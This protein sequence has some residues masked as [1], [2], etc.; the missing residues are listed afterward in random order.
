MKL[1]ELLTEDL[2]KSVQAAIDKANEGKEEKD[3][4][5]FVDLSEGGYVGKGK[6]DS[7]Q[8]DYNTLKE[9]TTK[10]N[11]TIEDLKKGN[12]DNE[13][14]QKKISDLTADLAKTKA[15]G[16]KVKKT[17]AIQAALTEAGCTDS[18]YITYKMGGADA[19]EF[20]DDGK[21]KDLE[22]KVKD[23]KEN[24]KSFFKSETGG[25]Y[26]P[27][28][29]GGTPSTNPF[30]KDTFSLTAQSKLMKESPEQARAL[31]AEAGVKL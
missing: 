17:Y 20:G 11:A 3:R 16:E 27:E 7:L 13:A 12:K 23:A 29:G 14:L 31:A 24:F 15:E 21:L 30:A 8:A 1:S 5:K 28:N 26:K 25:G 2:Y 9:T 22:S 6:Y 19:F 4:V 18:D 10:Q